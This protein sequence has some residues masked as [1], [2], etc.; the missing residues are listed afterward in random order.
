M[1]SSRIGHGRVRVFLLSIVAVLFA[2]LAAAAADRVLVFA[3]ASTKDAVE[4]VAEDYRV[5]TGTPV[6]VSLASSGTLAR[7]I[8]AGAPADIFLSANPLWMDYLADR[9][10]IDVES[11]AVAAGNRLVIVRPKASTSRI[12]TPDALLGSG[13]FAMGDPVH[14]PAGIY[15]RDALERLG[16][17]DDVGRNAAFGENVRVALA[18]VARGDV[19]A[20]IVYKSDAMLSDDIEIAFEFPEA[21]H[22]PIVYPV[23]LTEQADGEAR[24]FLAYLLERA[25][26]GAFARFGFAKPPEESG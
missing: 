12:A 20:A 17:W 18:K 8:E 25:Q 7:Q 19:D 10:L 4:A 21:G 11:R 5:Q 22:L 15:A 14:V 6:I 26:G 3:A 16:L 23:A 13:R 2:T 1:P 9:G 24:A